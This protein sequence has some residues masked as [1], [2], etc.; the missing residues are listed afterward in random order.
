MGGG[1][2]PLAIDGDTAIS[3]GESRYANGKKYSNIFVCRFDGDGRCTEFREWFMQ[4]PKP[5]AG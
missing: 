4:P 5:S 2:R 3:I 1:Y